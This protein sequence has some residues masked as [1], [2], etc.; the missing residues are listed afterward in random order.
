MPKLLEPKITLKGASGTILVSF[1]ALKF[2]SFW[3]NCKIHPALRTRLQHGGS[4]AFGNSRARKESGERLSLSDS[5]RQRYSLFGGGCLDILGQDAHK[6]ASKLAVFI[7]QFLP[8]R[9][10]TR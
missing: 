1:H 6:A 10:H 8:T 7:H 2:V 5:V 9:I 4:L 3:Q